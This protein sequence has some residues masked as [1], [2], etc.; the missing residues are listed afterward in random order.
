M[1]KRAPVNFRP[2]EIRNKTFLIVDDF[3]DMRSMIK[4]MLQGLGVTQIKTVANGEDAVSAMATQRFDIILCDYNLGPGK[5]GQ[6]VLEEGRYRDLIGL[7]SLF[8]MITAENTVDMVMGAIEYEPDS[9]LTKPFNKDLLN[10]RLQKLIDKKRNLSDVEQ[11]VDKKAFE[12]AIAL[13]DRKLAAKPKNPGDLNKIKAELCFR[14]GDYK[15][16]REIYESVLA[17]REVTWARFG[18]GKAHFVTGE[19]AEARTLFENLLS[20]D[21]T[22]TA[23]Y[24]WLA[25]TLQLLGQSVEA[26][27]VLQRAIDLSPKAILRQQAL[28]ELALRNEDEETAGRALAQAVKMGQFSV[29]KNPAVTASYAKLKACTGLASEGL[30]ILK[31]MKLEFKGEPEAELFAS[32]AECLIQTEKGNSAAADDCYEQSAALYEKCS[33]SADPG[34]TLE[35]IRVSDA[36]GHSDKAKELLGLVVRNNHSDSEF[37]QKVKS[38]MIELEL[39]SDPVAFIEEIRKEIVQINNRGVDLARSGQ[40]SQAVELFQEAVQSMPANQLVN[41]NAARVLMMNIQKNGDGKQQLEKVKEYLDRARLVNDEDP[42]FRRVQAT[43]QQ[44]VSQA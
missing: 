3:G 41:L 26:Q 36:L 12:R 30:K 5:N 19:Y 7:G 40:L 11:A 15:Q 44:L 17:E 14:S 8:V 10:A 43:Y 22:F 23:A 42:G 28:G 1:E 33:E 9:Y 2:S 37:L 31:I 24:D 34:V 29:Y 32:T 27:A 4:S 39:E 20:D 21:E 16:A 35:M 38:L 13:L 18:M 6:Q 25:R